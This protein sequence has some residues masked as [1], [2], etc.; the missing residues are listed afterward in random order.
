MKLGGIAYTNI[1]IR[2]DIFRVTAVNAVAGKSRCV[3]KIF[4]PS[5]AVLARSVGVM[6]PRNTDAVADLK[7]VPPIGATA[8]GLNRAHNLVPRNHGRLPL[9][10]LALNN[11]KIGAAH[12]TMRDAN[13][14]FARTWIRR[15]DVGNNERVCIYRSRLI[16]QRSFHCSAF[17][18]VNSSKL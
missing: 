17:H 11:M 10:Q 15:S 18:F 14:N 6:E 2:D 9:R 5:T 13:E 1:F 7:F 4:R 8:E 12:A 16:E 3:A